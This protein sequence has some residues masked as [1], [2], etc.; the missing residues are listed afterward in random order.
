MEKIFGKEIEEILKAGEKKYLTTTYKK[1][2]TLISINLHGA[3]M[4][5]NTILNGDDLLVDYVNI[6]NKKTIFSGII[7]I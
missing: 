6:L 2:P 3:I 1:L 7:N 5:I 4:R